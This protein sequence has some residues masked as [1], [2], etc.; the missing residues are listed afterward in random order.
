MVSA[1]VCEC[2][3]LRVYKGPTPPFSSTKHVVCLFCFFP[4]SVLPNATYCAVISQYLLPRCVTDTS[5]ESKNCLT[6]MYKPTFRHLQWEERTVKTAQRSEDGISPLQASF[7]CTDWQCC[8]DACDDINELS[9]TVSSYSVWIQLS[10]LKRW[11]F[12]QITN[13]IMI[14]VIDNKFQFFSY[15]K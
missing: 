6:D 2:V 1:A 11:L 5:Y 9:D 13:L 12:T 7:K 14:I 3:R 10:Q 8:Y 15:P 4:K